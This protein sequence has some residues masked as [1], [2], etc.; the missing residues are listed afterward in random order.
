MKYL[1]ASPEADHIGD[2]YASI[3]ISPEWCRSQFRFYLRHYIQHFRHMSKLHKNAHD[4][5]YADRAH[6]TRNPFSTLQM[7]V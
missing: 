3:E 4:I 6:Y 5:V 7:N 1:F 2:I